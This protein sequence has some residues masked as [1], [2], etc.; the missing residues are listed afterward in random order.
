MSLPL[1][2]YTPQSQNHRVDGFEVPGD[3]QS[4]IY[5]AEAVKADTDLDTLIYAAYRQIY[6]EQQMLSCHRQRTLESQL[7]SGQITVRDFIRGLVISDSF[8]RLVYDCNNNYRFVQICIQRVLGREVYSDRE[9]IA[10]SIVLATKG[11]HGF[12]DELLNSSEYIDT[13]GDSTVPFQRRRILPQ[14]TQGELPFARMPR[15]GADYRNRLPQ[16]SMSS[17]D[18]A[19]L[20]YYRW[21]WQ[22]N[23]PKS[24]GLLGKLIVTGGAA[25]V[26]LL[27]IAKIFGF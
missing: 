12:I 8:R 1:L 5:T 22:K 20:D 2:T 15:Y 24:L 21:D 14:R 25:V 13:F 10:W 18:S 4:W 16:S 11:L 23:P 27:A 9:K 26:A 7:K 6:N 19:R 17:G 3:E